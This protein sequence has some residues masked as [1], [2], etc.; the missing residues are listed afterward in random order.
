MAITCFD[1]ITS[2]AQEIGKFNPD[3]GFVVEWHWMWAENNWHCSK[4]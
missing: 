2:I 3:I 4:F 1:D